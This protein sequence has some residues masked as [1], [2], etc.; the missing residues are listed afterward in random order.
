MGEEHQTTQYKV[1]KEMKNHYKIA[2]KYFIET[3]N[4]VQL[5]IAY[6]EIETYLEHYNQYEWYYNFN[7]ENVSAIFFNL[8]NEENRY[9]I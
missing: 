5:V 4:E 1:L 7:P 6:K 3:N 2:I 9:M 8:L